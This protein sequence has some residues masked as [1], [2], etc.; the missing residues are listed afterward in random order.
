M[1]LKLYDLVLVEWEDAH[2]E[3]SWY[4]KEEVEKNHC[5]PLLVKTVGF[6]VKKSKKGISIT[7][8]KASNN[9]LLGN[10]FVP[11]GMIKKVSKL[12]SGLI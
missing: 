11:A 2:S 10:F 5:L 9:A 6:L 8:G 1:Q 7:S 12:K 3:N 4:T